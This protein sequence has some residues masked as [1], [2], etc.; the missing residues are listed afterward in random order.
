MEIRTET[1]AKLKTYI[2][3]PKAI[4][5][6]WKGNETNKSRVEINMNCEK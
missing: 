6:K 2:I 3:S 4:V 5:K 1:V